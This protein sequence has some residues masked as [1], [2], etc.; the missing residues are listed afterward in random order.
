M[1]RSQ[2]DVGTR[3]A[4]VLTLFASVG[5]MSACKK[6]NDYVLADGTKDGWVIIEL[7]NANCPAVSGWW[8][9]EFRIPQS[10]YLCTSNEPT[11]SW[12][13][14]RFWV[15]DSAGHRSRVPT[16]ERIHLQAEI[17]VDLGTCRLSG[18]A[19]WYGNRQRVSG[20]SASIIRAQSQKCK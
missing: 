17:G 8:H 2:S 1:T 18:M 7:E 11:R 10:G 4:F 20:D 5:T 15:E 12:V 14:D 13:Y 3:I 6:V 9:R 16:E 19:F